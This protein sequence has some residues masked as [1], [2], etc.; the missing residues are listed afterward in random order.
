M[1][2]YWPHFVTNGFKV[3]IYF[4]ATVC[5]RVTWDKNIQSLAAFRHTLKSVFLDFPSLAPEYKGSR[6]SVE[7]DVKTDSRL[8][9]EGVDGTSN[10]YAKMKNNTK[11][12]RDLMIG[13]V[14]KCRCNVNKVTWSPQHPS[15]ATTPHLNPVEFVVVVNA[16]KQNPPCCIVHVW[17]ENCA[18]TQFSGVPQQDLSE[19]GV[20]LQEVRPLCP[21]QLSERDRLLYK[22]MS[23]SLSIPEV[24]QR[25]STDR[26]S[27]DGTL[28]SLSL[29]TSRLTNCMWGD[30]LYFF[31]EYH[32]H[33]FFPWTI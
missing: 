24:K 30:Y 19:H 31:L 8:A 3:L 22:L 4:I 28:H 14:P 20:W 27:A 10:T 23:Q 26:Y 33:L 5:S 29:L 25:E 6:K 12:W 7:V 2:I 18:Q 11:M 9:I 13:A 15:C 17:K 21:M 1:E 16:S 32:Q